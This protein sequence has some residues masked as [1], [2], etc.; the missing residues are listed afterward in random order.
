[1][2]NTIITSR[3][4]IPFAAEVEAS[5]PILMNG[6]R[7]FDKNFVA[8]NGSTVDVIIPGYGT[9]NVGPDMSGV[10]LSYTAAKVSVTLVQRNVGVSLTQ[11]EQSL[12]LSNF[13]EQ[14]AAPYG[15]KLGSDIQKLA[16][17]ELLLKADTA[18]ILAGA[19]ETVTTGQY[20][21]IGT[22]VTNLHAARAS[23]L[24]FGAVQNELANQ[25]QNSGLTLFNPSKTVESSFLNGGL[26]KFRGADW[27]ET[28]D[29]LTLT[30]GTHTG[31]AVVG[32]VNAGGDTLTLSS[33]D[34]AGTYKQGEVVY[35]TGV[36]AVDIYGLALNSLYAFVV[37]ADASVLANSVALSIKPIILSGPLKNV[38]VGA[39]PAGVATVSSQGVANVPA[40]TIAN[41][42]YLR[43]IVWDKMA[44]VY[45][46]AALQPLAMAKTL[47]DFKFA[48]GQALTVLA[49]K[50]T[51][52]AKGI[53]IVRWDVLTG[54][55]LARS[56][57]VSSI[58]VKVS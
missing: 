12:A 39:M 1:M 18:V 11:V 2:T 20:A 45:A 43:G 40:A 29:I 54:F 35:L 37:Q 47:G 17:Q 32:T 3:I 25:I 57:W 28:P 4:A 49:Q 30:A 42:T 55:L 19:G 15:I 58:L 52:F 44:F 33:G 53:D 50:G 34:L 14:I 36:K 7:Q 16:A 8:G 48:N 51:D 5:M 41:S 9:V 27:Y 46:A 56:N 26:G 22:A 10:D 21:T 23:G 31:T 24:S 38:S 13:D 6:N